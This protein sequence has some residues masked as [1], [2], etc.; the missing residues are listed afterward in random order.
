MLNR[1]K[2]PLFSPVE[3]ISLPEIEKLELP[4]GLEIY[5]AN[6]A[7]QDIIKV[8]LVLEGGSGRSDLP[9]LPVLFSKMLIGGT[10]KR[11]ATQIVEDFDQYGGFIEVGQKVESMNITLYGLRRFLSQYLETLFEVLDEASF[12]EDELVS[13]KD[14]AQN[15]LDLNMEKSSFLASRAYKALIFG[16][17]H[18][19]GRAFESEDIDVVQREDLFAFYARFVKEKAFKIF[20]SGKVGHEEV[21]VLTKFFGQRPFEQVEAE[22]LTFDAL[23][24]QRKLIE[25]ADSMQSTLRM[26]KLTVGRRHPDF[27]KMMV[28]N[29]VFGGFF[30]SRLMKNIREK[31]GFTYGIS[32]S[33]SPIQDIGFYAIGSDVI[34]AHTLDTLKEIEMEAKKLQEEKVSDDELDL[35]KNYLSGSF[36]GSITTAFE[37]MDRHRNLVLYKLPQ[38]FYNTFVDHIRAVSKEDVQEMAQKYLDIQSM[39]EVIVGERI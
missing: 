25:R 10:A 4:N 2:A 11:T 28:C 14:N 3:F 15:A 8:E 17:T 30:G 18:P 32:S 22:V 1:T 6:F 34:K 21:E 35:V 5:I 37:I 38:D 20:V 7:D 24:P 9:G 19:Y 12:P 16:E 13:Q 36:A 33:V 29:T 26:G 23:P 27:F 31:K 39:S